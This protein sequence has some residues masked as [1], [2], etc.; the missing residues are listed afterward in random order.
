MSI[1]THALPEEK[2]KAND[3]LMEVTDQNPALKPDSSIFTDLVSAFSA[4]P[5]S[6]SYTRGRR[7]S[8]I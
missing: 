5:S 4:Q 1:Y 3:G 2:K 6:V 8:S 7:N